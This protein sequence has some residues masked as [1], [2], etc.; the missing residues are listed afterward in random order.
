M[1]D[2][3]LPP[4]PRSL[5]L[6]ESVIQEEEKRAQAQPNVVIPDPRDENT[7]GS[8]S[9]EF[10]DTDKQQIV[11]ENSLS[12]SFTEFKMKD[13]EKTPQI[14]KG[15]PIAGFKG[16]KMKKPRSRSNSNERLTTKTKKLQRPY[17]A[18]YN[19]F[20]RTES[21][22]NKVMNGRPGTSRGRAKSA[23]QRA[24]SAK[25]QR[26]RSPRNYSSDTYSSSEEYTRKKKNYRSR[27]RSR[28]SSS[29]SREKNDK[30]ESDDFFDSDKGSDRENKNRNDS[31][32]RDSSTSSSDSYTS[33]DE[34]KKDNESSNVNDKQAHR[35]GRSESE[36][37]DNLRRVPVED[38]STSSLSSSSEDEMESKRS[39][40]KPPRPSKTKAT[41]KLKPLLSRK[42]RQNYKVF[43]IDP[44]LYLEGKLHQKYSE[45]E[46]LM[47]CSFVDQKSH[48][49]RHH[50][51][52]MELLNDQYT[53]ASHG[54]HSSATII[55]RS[56]PADVRNRSHRPSSAKPS[57]SS[58]YGESDKDSSVYDPAYVTLRSVMTAEHLRQTNRIRTDINA[59]RPS[60]AKNTKKKKKKK[61]EATLKSK[62]SDTE[63]DSERLSYPSSKPSSAS[64]TPRATK[65]HIDH[66]IKYTDNEK[67]R[68]WLKEKDKTY[69]QKAKEER[70]KKREEREKLIEEANEKLEKRIESQKYVKVWMREKNKVLTK[71]CQEERR[72]EKQEMEQERN[73]S[74]SLPGDA[75]RIRPQSAPI[76]RP[77]DIHIDKHQLKGEETPEHV[78]QQ[79][80]MKREIDE[81]NK[82]AESLHQEPHPPQTKFIYK[83]PVAGKIKL[84]MEVRGKS[85][86]PA[87]N[88]ADKG[89]KSED[90]GETDRGNQARMSY[91]DWVKKK[92]ELDIELKKHKAAEKQRELAKSDPELERIIPELGKRRVQDK[93]KM[94]KRIDTG[95]KHF[96][97]KANK[98]FG[99]GDF[100]GEAPERPRSA[101]RLES[102][103]SDSDQPALTVKQLQRPS[104]AP[105]RGRV[106]PSPKRSAKS[107]RKAIIPQRVDNIMNNED[108]TNP[109]ATDGVDGSNPYSIPFT[110]EK[111]IPQHL[112]E[113]QRR[114][115]ADVVTKNLDEIEQRAL[116]NAELIREG[117][118]DE[119]IEKYRKEMKE[120][121]TRYSNEN[122][123]NY[124]SEPKKY[125]LT[126]GGRFPEKYIEREEEKH[127]PK[128]TE[129]MYSP[130]ARTDSS[131]SSSDE[132]MKENVKTAVSEDKIK[133]DARVDQA[134]EASANNE[135]SGNVEPP[136]LSSASNNETVNGID[137]EVT[138]HSHYKTYGNLNELQIDSPRTEPEPDTAKKEDEQLRNDIEKLK[139]QVEHLH[140]D[141]ITGLSDHS[142][143]IPDSNEEH[144]NVQE[145][146]TIVADVD[147]SLVG[148]LKESKRDETFDLKPELHEST[149]FQH[150]ET[151]GKD[152]DE[153]EATSPREDLNGS[154]KK[155]VSFN[156]HTEVFQS[157][158]SN[159]T[160]TVTPEHEE[161][162]PKAESLDAQSHACADDFENGGKEETNEVVSDEKETIGESTGAVFITNPDE[163]T[164]A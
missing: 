73:C 60:S 31:R 111:G 34:G 39:D 96:D 3:G 85:P 147:P 163:E 88:N 101:Y 108:N 116:L 121:I 20:N 122:N 33:N 52:Q 74:N 139:E 55:P 76:K 70:R 11:R 112:V 42:K 131:D 48:V 152:D 30:P 25:G 132:S 35:K 81:E 45:L 118:S 128:I 102:D 149:E 59:D 138:A 119:D 103:R 115:F 49:T 9:P 90:D 157:F 57:T 153:N 158:E 64:S 162:D 7:D 38:G 117:V 65:P 110:P 164:S 21:N 51:Y 68:K 58:H 4:R 161:F 140:L 43:Q 37:S 123:L 63:D 15:N 146:V 79:I 120:D 46:E 114:I 10:Y 17:S 12:A 89:N 28:S 155:R 47:Q 29:E 66:H 77:N 159:S 133:E 69:R 144:N 80:H 126:G 124:S 129:L 16:K 93:L 99:G 53:A 107:P 97:E 22:A 14:K 113:R 26:P 125:V 137:E 72:R 151:G 154:M 1:S 95:I 143:V 54:H 41:K 92:R 75:M 67:L 23:K 27:S 84:R 78:R 71:K 104:T 6:L 135:G 87:K 86:T 136:V 156:E 32:R 148:I 134:N 44:D 8:G 62:K 2:P 145:S 50:I 160:D 13:S 127:Q 141:K 83:R 18:D 24:S 98:S 61:I 142:Q 106:P 150:S 40:T 19:K 130:R 5:N 56:L 105:S 91:E 100:D 109:Y 36:S 82:Q 94:R